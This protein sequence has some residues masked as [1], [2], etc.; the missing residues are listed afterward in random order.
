MQSAQ[1]Y[2]FLKEEGGFFNTQDGKDLKRLFSPA[3]SVFVGL[4]GEELAKSVKSCLQ[5]LCSDPDVLSAVFAL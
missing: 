2:N 3:V 4:S 1:S 5:C